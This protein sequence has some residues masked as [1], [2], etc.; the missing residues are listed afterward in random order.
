MTVI[1]LMLLGIVWGTHA[2]CNKKREVLRLN[3]KLRKAL[4]KI[5][6]NEK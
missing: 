6:E 5:E 3:F 4:E 2:Y 1:I